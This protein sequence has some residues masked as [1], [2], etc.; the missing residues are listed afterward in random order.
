MLGKQR[1]FEVLQK[2]LQYSSADQ[3]EAK[4][5]GENFNLTR[6]ANST[7]HQNLNRVNS[8][9]QVRVVFGK[10]MGIATTNNLEEESIK[11]VVEKASQMASI[12]EDNP[13]FT[14][15]PNKYEY[16]DTKNYYES[17]ANYTAE[18]RA[19]DVAI[20]A[21]HAAEKGFKIFGSH[22]T[23]QEELAVVNSLGLEAY[24]AS[25]Y[26]YLRT[27]VEGENGTGYADF[28]NRDASKIDADA[29]GKEA[30]ARCALAQDPKPLPTGEYEV[31]FLPYAVSDIVRFPAYIGFVGQAYEEG[32]SYMANKMGEQLVGDNISIWDDGLNTATLNIPFDV[33][34]VPKNG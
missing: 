27:V 10:K 34:G 28:L 11:R 18:Q 31:V 16:H 17:T 4:I 21:K 12:Q 15:L 33:E 6:F 5:V 8:E 14:S 24:N 7:I 23:T 32:R 29:I 2:A 20:L 13:D 30:V 19:A 25:T 3:T 1:C 26:A 22:I 9:L